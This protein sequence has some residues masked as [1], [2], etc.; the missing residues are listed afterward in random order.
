M[1]A[2]L[3]SQSPIN[4]SPKLEPPNRPVTILYQSNIAT[5][6]MASFKN[7]LSLGLLALFAAS[8]AAEAQTSQSC[9]S[10]LTNLEVCAPFALPG[11]APPSD[12]CCS[13]LSTVNNDCLCN[14]LRIVSRMPALCNVG[15]VNCR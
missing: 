4:L 5:N 7:V 8:L 15:R 14:T 6:P 13:A 12:G 3:P 1:F 10:Q 2:I 9:S 11:A